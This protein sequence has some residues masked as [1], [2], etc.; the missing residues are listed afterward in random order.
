M[1]QNISSD[2]TPQEREQKLIQT[3]PRE[4]EAFH[5]GGFL[6]QYPRHF[7]YVALY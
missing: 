4:S 5:N 3:D 1:R 6:A 2:K 7:A